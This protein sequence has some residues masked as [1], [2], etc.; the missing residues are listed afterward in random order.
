MAFPP[1][2]AR[3]SNFLRDANAGLE[4]PAPLKLDAELNAII[5]VVNQLVLKQRGFTNSDGTLRNFATATAQALAGTEDFVATA[6]QTAFVTTIPWTAAFTAENVFVYIAGLKLDTADVAVADAGNGFL[7]V[8]IAA[9]DV[10]TGVTVAAFESGAGLLSRL[11]TISV[12]DGASLIAI[13]DAGGLYAAVTV[14]AA[15]QEVM[16]DLNTLETNVGSTADLIRRTGTV[17]FTA[18]QSMG[19]FRLTNVADGVGAQDAVTMAQFAAY[20]AV[21]DA[22]A[23]YFLRLD[24]TTPMAANLPMGNNKVTGMANG[25]NA[26]D[27]VNKSQLD[28][29]LP[30][31]GGTM[32]GPIAMGAQKITG[33][34]AGTDATDAV[35]LA[36]AQSLV[37]N[38][39]TLVAYQVAGTQA[40]LV[41]AGISKIQVEVFGGGGGGKA[42]AGAV[43]ARG[44]G[45]G[46]YATAVLTV[47]PGESLTIVVGAG[48]AGGAAPDDGGNSSIS[49]GVTA[50]VT[51]G[52]GQDGDAAGGGAAGGTYSFGTGVTGFGI[53]GGYGE[54]LGFDD[55]GFDE[56]YDGNGGNCP[57]G[58]NGGTGY[59][60]TESPIITQARNGDAPGGGGG[61]SIVAAGSGAAGAVLIRY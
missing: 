1:F 2:P 49:R 23:T 46:A 6:S 50:L 7:K 61:A 9:Q 21:W 47:V 26:N 55:S 60:Q 15:L 8:T 37:A 13:N 29:Y 14:E 10:G 56:Y 30:L 40:F 25:T 43:N 33:L 59:E 52:G 17:P 38:F 4:S 20:T 34:A 39:S 3:V 19:S 53:N 12:S 22:L 42:A 28:L 45:G 32:S 5:N 11:Q 16:T 57:R 48:G 58:G 27:A 24:G 36:Q 18:N 44:G 35:N 31:A 54:S 41:P 51:A